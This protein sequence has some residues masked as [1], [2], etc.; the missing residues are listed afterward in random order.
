MRACPAWRPLWS[1]SRNISRGQLTVRGSAA[2][3]S[4]Q[5][6]V[7]DRSDIG[8]NASSILALKEVG[9][10]RVAR[11]VLSV[12]LSLF[13]YAQRIKR[14]PLGPGRGEGK[15]IAVRAVDWI[16]V[17]PAMA[18]VSVLAA[19]IGLTYSSPA[20]DGISGWVAVSISTKAVMPHRK[21]ALDVASR[22]RLIL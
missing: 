13:E 5:I 16:A 14:D 2:T 22:S 20:P 1:I 12:L 21:L 4:G 19:A 9:C 3:V 8:C 10:N 11:A 7:D 15:G 17:S 6:R 18:G